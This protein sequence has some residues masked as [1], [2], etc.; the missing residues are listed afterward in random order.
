MNFKRSTL[1]TAT[2]L[3]VAAIAVTS[4]AQPVLEEVIVTAQKKSASVNDVPITMTAL[5]TN[6]IRNLGITDAMDVEAFATN[7]DIKGTI[8]GTNPA[9]TIRGIGLND[10]NANNNPAVGVYIDEVFLVSAGMLNFSTFDIERIE[11]LKGPQGTLYG[12]NSTGGALNY[13]TA[14]PDFEPSGY[15]SL[16]AGDYE[17]FEAEGAY[18]NAIN[19]N[20]AYRVAGK[21]SDQ[22]ENYIDN[23]LGDDFD[24]SDMTSG[25]IALRYQGDQLLF[26]TS[27]TLGSQSVGFTP[28]KNRGYADINDPNLIARCPSAASGNPTQDFSCVS[29]LLGVD[30]TFFNVDVES[31]PNQDFEE[32]TYANNL[33]TP[34]TDTDSVFWVGRFDYEMG[35]NGTFTSVTSYGDI[36]RDYAD[37]VYGSLQGYHYFDAARE[38]TIE[39]ITQ[40]LRYSHVTDSLTWTTGVFYSYD[41]VTS[42]ANIDAS[43]SLATMYFIDY[44]QETTAAALFSQ[45]EYSFSDTWSA[46]LG[47]RYSWEERDFVGGT[48]DLNPFDQSV[49]LYLP[50]EFGGFGLPPEFTGPLPLT[51]GTRFKFDD[52]NVSWRVGL[53]WRPD[54]NW[55]IFGNVSTGFKSGIVFSDISFV[56][57]D[58]GP[59]E[60]EELL[61]Y[62]LGFKGTLAGGSVQFNGAV[63]L[64]DYEDIQTQ[65]P[66]ALALT[67]ANAEEA[68]VTGAELELNWLPVEGLNLRAGISWLDSEL[69]SPGLDD[70]LLPNA[71][72][73][74][75]NLIARYDL[76]LSNGMGIGL[77]ADMKYSDEMFKEAT[78]DVLAQSD[79]YT[80]YNARISLHGVDDSWQLAL[81]GKN[82]GNEDYLEHTFVTSFFTITAD[83]YGAPRTYGATLS[84]NF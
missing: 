43:D 77:Q 54:D 76:M 45:F 49:I 75:Y 19:D 78:N 16:T 41:E 72:E 1:A 74:Q 42:D 82:L 51:A 31:F 46:E 27:L 3:I 6:D 30:G 44:E 80:V 33:D 57:E 34:T 5:S 52:D 48:T 67:F 29:Q 61:A 32:A 81:W 79:D 59:L 37:S 11:V 40:E 68:E 22:G 9:I 63:F 7:I 70:N 14:K 8:G 26:D 53:N 73:L 66:T 60:P 13:F 50:P 65:V 21:W 55:L 36:E 20:W 2:G 38:E 71:A 62:E 58:M 10:F 56:P 18:G 25:R 28:F 12:R 69:D 35:D 39:Q 24:G 15:I 4:Q 47:L 23:V 84:Y 64:Y 17:L 83:L